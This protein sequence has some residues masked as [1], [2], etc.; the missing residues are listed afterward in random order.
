VGATIVMRR[1]RKIAF[2]GLVRGTC[3]TE[4]A[5]FA[6]ILPVLFLL[7]IGIL[8]AGQ[9]FH[10][11]TA[12]TNAA[13][14]GARAAVNP[15]CSTC[16]GGDPTTN[17]WNAIDKDLQAA[18]INSLTLQQP[19]NPPSVC[20]CTSGG[21]TAGCSPA[22]VP[23]DDNQANICVQGVNHTGPGN[24]TLTEG[25]VQLSTSAALVGSGQ[26]GQAGGAGECGISVS[27]QYPYSF[28]LPGTVFNKQVINLRAQAQMRSETQ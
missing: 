14:D 1:F 27:F 22:T 16:G 17:A 24:T 28:W 9:A 13:R 4:V 10:I 21:S 11:Y 18:H 26:N 15:A 19:A 2:L 7:L 20:A 8:W 5:E 23:C 12:I 25:L 3:G 6:M